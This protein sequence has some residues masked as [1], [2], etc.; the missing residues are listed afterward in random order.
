M[1]K[2]RVSAPA[3]SAN[4]GPGFDCVALALALNNV[5]EL[6]TI[7]QG[8]NIDKELD[9]RAAI[10][11]L[12]S[13]IGVFQKAGKA[14]TGLKVCIEQ[15][16]PLRSGLGGEEAILV[17]SGIAANVLIGSPLSRDE[18]LEIT[19]KQG[20]HPASLLASLHGGLIISSYDS[21]ELLYRALEVKVPRVVIALP[22]VTLAYNQLP[23]PEVVKLKDA[24]F[25]IGRS[26]L[27][28]HSMEN[29]DFNLL[30]KALE[31]RLQQKTRTTLIKGYKKAV[32]SARKLGAAAVTLCG[33]G[34]SIIAFA[35]SNHDE[36][37]EAL[38]HSLGSASRKAVQTWILHVDT[39][40]ISISE[41]NVKLQNGKVGTRSSRKTAAAEN[42]ESL[43]WLTEKVR[44]LEPSGD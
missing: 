33:T 22:E 30:S 41:M 32:D 39:Q 42:S 19:I 1:S 7:E 40:G 3:T 6:S 14:P 21:G 20:G 31:D 28:V 8:I 44:E 27:V 34:P 9:D 15:H 38:A 43:K 4:L 18:V 36:I 25:N 26:L 11:A 12:K 24:A 5:V 17:A 2:V 10:L 35:N 29:S 16:I 23:L 37:K 13:A